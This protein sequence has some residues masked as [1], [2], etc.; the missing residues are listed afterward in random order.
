MDGQMDKLKGLYDNALIPAGD[1]KNLDVDVIGTILHDDSLMAALVSR[2]QYTEY[3]K[4]FFKARFENPMTGKKESL[5]PERWTVE[6]LNE[7][8]RLKPEA[9]AKE[10][11][12]DPS[13]GSLE[14]IRREDFRQWN[15]VENQAVLYDQD[16]VVS[17]RWKLTDCKA[18]VGIDLAWEEKKGN[19]FA[20]IVPGLVTPDNQL[21]VDTYICKKGLRPDEFERIIFDMDKRYSAMTG[22]RVCFGFEKAMLEKLMKWFLKEAMKRTGA[23]LWF[24]DIQWG[25]TD[26]VARI[27]YR[28]ANRYSQHS[29]FH[30]RG[31]GDLENQLIRLRSAAHDDIAD[32]LA[33][34]PEMLIYAS[35]AEKEKPK[36]DLFRFL[37]KNTHQWKMKEQRNSKYIFGS[38][39][40]GS[41]IDAKIGLVATHSGIGL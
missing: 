14:T 2:G 17:S 33:M 6:E 22:K 40:K 36:E 3:R 21:L 32:A 16:G 1:I 11:Q 8:E 13:S 25:T 27:M 20:A 35:I 41:V 23:Y 5:W 9:F 34:L 18:A 39:N 30:R 15:I 4:L 38:K 10:M 31:M 12:G 7:M 37:Q 26:K 29:V 19:D 24:K 28:I